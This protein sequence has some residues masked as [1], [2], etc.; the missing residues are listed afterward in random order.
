[1]ISST[2]LSSPHGIAAQSFGNRASARRSPSRGNTVT[3]KAGF[4]DFLA[5]K[6]MTRKGTK[7]PAGEIVDRLIQIAEPTNGGLR[8]SNAVS[9]E[10]RD[11]VD[12]LEKY[13][14]KSPLSSD[15]IFGE[16]ELI[17]SS[18][19]EVSGGPIRSSLGQ[20]FF[21]GQVATQVI[22]PP[23][24]C[25][26]KVS[27][28]TLGF[29]PG[30][31]QQQGEL[32]PLDEVTYE[33]LI[34]G[35]P[36]KKGSKPA[37][38]VVETRYLDDR[39]RVA[40]SVAQVEGQQG[41]LFVF[42]RVEEEVG[43]SK[44]NLMDVT[45]TNSYET[46]SGSFDDIKEKLSFPG[47]QIFKQP[48]M[49]TKAERSYAQRTGAQNRKTNKETTNKKDKTSA[50]SKKRVIEDERR[51]AREVAAAEKKKAEEERRLAREKIEAEKAAR[52]ELQAASRQQYQELSSEVATKA[53]ESRAASAAL[54]NSER[55]I[56]KVIRAAETA[57][58]KILQAAE[59]S[60]EAVEELTIL[61]SQ[62]K[63]I[64]SSIK[65]AKTVL[66][67]IQKQIKLKE[68]ILRPKLGNRKK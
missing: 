48:G 53:S 57:R 7:N 44:S 2:L 36:N 12:N 58:S 15:L 65:S 33:L 5:P 37:R 6:E 11:L 16:W 8:A 18:K 19:P 40:Q 45:P 50:A 9:G 22:S 21:P 26:N 55:E 34:S 41:V 67:E 52:A 32:E 60:E 62:Q 54:R 30:A 59:R 35:Y 24:I 63:E 68:N 17:Y 46:L 3:V 14:P 13:A 66:D 38:R 10:I 28:K 1:M 56:S 31:V 43:D 25:T 51:R 61:K 42:R 49:A 39:L 47:T 20:V 29:I 23:N 4:L 27:F 64:E